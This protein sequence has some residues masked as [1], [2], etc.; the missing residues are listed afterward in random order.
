VLVEPKLGF[1]RLITSSEDAGMGKA[2]LILP[3]C[4]GP[5][6]LPARPG[7]LGL[8]PAPLTPCKD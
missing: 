3:P 1:F 2:G 8:P 5:T 7:V 6:V 4:S